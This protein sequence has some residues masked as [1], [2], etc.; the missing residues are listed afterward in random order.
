MKRKNQR[1]LKFFL[2]RVYELHVFG[3]KS[4]NSSNLQKFALHNEMHGLIISK[5]MKQSSLQAMFV[6]S[7]A[8]SRNSTQ[9]QS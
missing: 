4:K 3:Q 9:S 1:K 5:K 2:S 8:S 7:K 6:Y